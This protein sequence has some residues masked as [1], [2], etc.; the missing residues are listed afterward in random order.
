MGGD[1]IREFLLNEDDSESDLIKIAEGGDNISAQV[2]MEYLRKNYDS[3][4]VWCNDCDGMAVKK[5]QCCLIKNNND[6]E[7]N[8]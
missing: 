2:A 3:T 4:Y 8:F 6:E 1:E 5:N 7:V